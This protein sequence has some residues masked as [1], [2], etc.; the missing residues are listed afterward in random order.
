[1]I[2]SSLFCVPID[3]REKIMHYLVLQILA[4]PSF[5]HDVG[6]RMKCAWILAQKKYQ[7]LDQSELQEILHRLKAKDEDYL[8]QGNWD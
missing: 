6:R 3:M 7:K 5:D 1:M 4:D 8:E 2:R